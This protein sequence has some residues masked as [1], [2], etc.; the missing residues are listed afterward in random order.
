MYLAC[1]GLGIFHK[2]ICEILV[3]NISSF[4][5]NYFQCIFDIFGIISFY[6]TYL[7]HARKVQLQKSHLAYYCTNKL[8]IV[9]SYDRKYVVIQKTAITQD[10]SIPYMRQA[11]SL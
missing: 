4:N 5:F 11:Y 6:S 9:A 1:S 8:D 7:S 2:N 10:M 3:T